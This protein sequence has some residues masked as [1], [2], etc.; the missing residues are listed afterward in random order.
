MIRLKQPIK[1]RC[2]VCG[3]LIDRRQ[4]DPYAITLEL[5]RHSR[6]GDESQCRGSNLRVQKE[7]T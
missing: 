1:I 2:P 5:P 6:R 7:T 3:R 4:V